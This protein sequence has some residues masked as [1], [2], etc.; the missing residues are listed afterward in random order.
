[1]QDD[2][3]GKILAAQFFLAETTEGY[4][5]LLQSL[6]RRFGVPTAFYGDRSGIFVRHD[7]HW[8]VEELAASA[9]PPSSVAL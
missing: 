2:A 3:S 8:T 1:M 9:S 4:F 7:E 6:L 5:H